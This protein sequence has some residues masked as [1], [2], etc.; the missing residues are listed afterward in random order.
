[1]RRILSVL[2][3]LMAW[4]TDSWAA[5]SV[6]PYHVSASLAEVSNLRAFQ[7]AA[8]IS[9]G[10]KA[11]LASNHFAVA[12][13]RDTQLFY[14]YEENDYSNIPSFISSDLVLQLYHIFYDFTLRSTEQEKLEP[15]LKALTAGMVKQS[16]KTY[17]T[18]QD[19]SIREAAL[20][21]VAYFDVAARQLGLKVKVPAAAKSMVADACAKIEG[22]QE[23]DQTPLFAYK[24]DFSQ[25][26][27]RGHYTRS[28][29]LKKYFRAMMWYGL[30]PFSTETP[31][32]PKPM[33][34]R[35]LVMT[36]DLYASGMDVKWATIYE[37]TAFYVGVA[38]DLKPGEIRH[39]AA[40]IYGHVTSA[41]AY[42]ND[43]KFE[44]FVAGFDK[45]RSPGIEG[46]MTG[47]PGGR[48]FR[49]MGQRY[50]ADSAVMQKLVNWPDR[51][52]PTGLDVMSVFGSAQATAI[53]D[54]HPDLYQT[55][56]WPEYLPRRAE[57]TK[58]FAATPAAT[59]N[60]NLY[61]GWLDTLRTLNAEVPAGYPSFMQNAAWRSKTLDTSLASWAELRH[62]TIL[63]AKQSVTAEC[64]GDY[65]K[66]PTI[67]GYVE[68]NVAFYERLLAL[69]K[70]SR[71]GLN[72]R[73]LLTD[74]VNQKFGDVEDLLTEL[75]DISLKE[76]SNQKLTEEQYDD[77]R[78]I[79]GK[80]EQLS[81]SVMGT[82]NWSLVDN[83]DQDVACV[84][85]VH[86]D[87]HNALEEGVGHADEILV[88]VPIDGKLVLTRG[89]VLS[90]YEFLQPSSD[91]LTDEEWQG[92]ITKGTAP[93]PP[94]WTKSYR[95]PKGVKIDPTQ[96]KYD[97]TGC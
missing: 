35:V 69:T 51:I 49:F 62:D 17:R 93:E 96:A 27:P 81:L 4:S 23:P 80:I 65:V 75:R 15:V 40:T 60:S 47:V 55:K 95:T 64:G 33:L 61:W 7:K 50:I 83:A 10:E 67:H 22:H 86:S 87:S 53:L 76:L 12:P 13:T 66:P 6:K 25:F 90:Y 70:Q 39:L 52:F 28:A 42:V 79:G 56:T 72:R 57:L 88:I 21:N 77:I 26:V 46:Q 91:R 89:A 9:P 5:P 68:P 34:L 30:V 73:H 97:R 31:V 38:D 43:A 74:E 32:D 37:P 11:L 92:K 84:A 1:V 71:E 19:P 24:V 29:D 54:N 36:R 44:A 94:V 20:Y 16:L 41:D 59:W 82:N 18:A 78:Y 58:Q 45:L 3:L 2:L 48:Q 8:A 14:V 85:D 63:Y